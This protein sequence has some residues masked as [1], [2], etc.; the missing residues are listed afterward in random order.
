ML[1]AQTIEHCFELTV[2]DKICAFPKNMGHFAKLQIRRA[3][4]NCYGREF[5]LVQR[6]LLEFMFAIPSRSGS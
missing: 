3:K 2:Q 4:E 1:S 6:D 5:P